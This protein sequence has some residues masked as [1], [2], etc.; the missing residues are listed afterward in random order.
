LA[1]LGGSGI[2]EVLTLVRKLAAEGITVIIIEHTMQAMVRLVDRF[3]VLNGGAVLAE[4]Q[5]GDITQDPAVV[6]AYLGKR[7]RMA[8]A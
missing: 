6:D 7:W 1:G 3:L 2:E 5:P 8:H 4:G